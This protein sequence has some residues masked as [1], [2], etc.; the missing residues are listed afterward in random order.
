MRA[1]DDLLLTLL[2]VYQKYSCLLL[3]EEIHKRHIPEREK[4]GFQKSIRELKWEAL[5]FI[6]YGTLVPSQISR[7]NNVCEMYRLLI[8]M[9]GVAESVGE[10]KEKIGLLNEEQERLDARRKAASA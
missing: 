2:A 1:E 4:S 5:E 9:N 7:W 3:N 6:A 8:Q 10:I